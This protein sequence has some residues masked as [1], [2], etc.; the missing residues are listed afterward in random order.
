MR[1]LHCFPRFLPERLGGAEVYGDALLKRLQAQGV[2][3]AV[4]CRRGFRNRSTAPYRRERY[5]QL[6]L[7][8]VGQPARRSVRHLL[9]QF[10][11]PI[12]SP[13]DSAFDRAAAALLDDFRPDVVHMHQAGPTSASLIALARTAGVLVVMTLHDLSVM[14]LGGH[15]F[16]RHSMEPCTELPDCGVRCLESLFPVPRC[17]QHVSVR[18]V[19]QGFFWYAACRRRALTSALVGRREYLL[20]QLKLVDR[21][22]APSRWLLKQYIA[23]RID[24][25]KLMHADYGTEVESLAGGRAKTAAPRVRFGFLGRTMPE[26]GVHL[27]IEAFQP[28]RERA[29]LHVYAVPSPGWPRYAQYLQRVADQARACFHQPVDPSQVIEVFRGI[30]VLVVPTLCCENSPLVVH[31]AFALGT[32][33]IVPDAG[34]VRELVE[35]MRGGL[36]FRAGD[37]QDMADAMRRCVDKPVVLDELRRTIPSVKA[38]EEHAREL[39]AIYQELCHR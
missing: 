20:R 35:P 29:E 38:M 22:I 25:V 19:S 16:R 14:C 17:H 23:W 13:D 1:V 7:F 39:I 21:F 6:P 8:G 18:V 24:P 12:E 4:L 26:K 3:V 31:E 10:L 34:G 5:D 36:R 2:E 30:D 11:W 28:L 33:V 27:L 9:R 37:V 15:K 32:P